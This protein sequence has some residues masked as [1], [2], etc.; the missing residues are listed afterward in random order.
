MSGYPGQYYYYY[1][2]YYY[3]HHHHHRHH[4]LLLLHLVLA[5]MQGI[6][7]YILHTNHVS[8]VYSVAALL[9]LQFVVHVMLFRP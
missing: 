2:Y 8:R 4:L 5:F 7:N 6:Y 9:Y 1:Y 3:Y